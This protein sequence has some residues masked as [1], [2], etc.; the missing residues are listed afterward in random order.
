MSAGRPPPDTLPPAVPDPVDV[1]AREAAAAKD[2]RRVA[3]LAL[4]TYGEE[5]LRFLAAQAKDEV[6]ANEAFSLFTEAMWRGLVGFRWEC[7]LRTWCYTLARHAWYRL[8]RERARGAETVPLL[9][10]GSIAIDE[11]ATR[12]KDDTPVF[13]TAEVKRKLE[14]LRT[15]LEIDDQMLLTLRVDRS[16]A[17]RDVARVMSEEDDDMSEIALERRTS[18]LRKRFMEL[19]EELRIKLD[20]P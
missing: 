10:S 6:A 9:S 20:E 5:I 2:W 1:E 17:W 18:R 11:L 19:K 7:S 16:M 4:E 14:A 3:T 12:V 8:L 15:Q 13:M